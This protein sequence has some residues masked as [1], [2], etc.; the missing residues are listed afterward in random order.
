MGA[1]RGADAVELK[2]LVL[3]DRYRIYQ[4]DGAAGMATVC[5]ARDVTTSAVVTVLVLEPPVTRDAG[6]VRRF[7]R[8]AEMAARRT[9]PYVAPIEDYGQEQG[10]C[11]MVTRY[12]Q[13]ATLRDVEQQ[14][15]ALPMVQCAWIT[16]CIASALEGALSSG[17]TFHGALRPENV[18]MTAS[19]D[20]Q[21]AGFGIAAASGAPDEILGRS[22]TRYAAPEQVEGR[23]IDIR[24]DLYA[25]GVM[26]YE[27]LTGHIPAASEAHAFLGAEDVA[28]T[29]DRMD[30]FLKDVPDQLRP[31]LSG[32]LAWD[33]DARFASPGDLIAMLVLAGFPAPQ[34][35]SLEPE[36]PAI[37][38]GPVF[39]M[40]AVPDVRAGPVSIVGMSE[41]YGQERTGKQAH[42]EEAASVAGSA[43]RAEVPRPEEGTAWETGAA[44]QVATHQPTPTAAAPGT[45][46]TRRRRSV[47]P[48]VLLVVVIGVVAYAAA[49]GWLSGRKPA[50]EGTTTPP[51]NQTVTTG[52]LEITSTPSGASITIDDK[53]IGATTPTTVSGLAPGSHTILLHLS[54]YVDSRKTVAVT[55]GRTAS[56]QVSL[57]KKADTT[58]PGT[59]PSTPV[60]P[61]QVQT[62]IR[63]TSTPAGAAITLDGKA[64]GSRTP[65]TLDVAPGGHLV[66]LSL[67]GYTTLTRSVDVT[68]GRHAS[69][70]V[71]LAKAPPVVSGL[72]RVTSKPAGAKVKVDGKVVAGTTPLTVSVAV[73]SH[74]LQVSLQGYET[75]T[76]TRVDVVKGIETVVVAQLVPVPADKD[77]VNKVSGFGFRY[78]GTWQIVQSQGSTEPPA[79][80]EVRSP[81]GASVRVTVTDAGG[82]T[83]EAYTAALKVELEKAGGVV[84]AVGPRTV[85]GIVYEHLVCTQGSVRTE[86]CML[87]SAGSMYRLACS[88]P[89]DGIVAATPGFLVILG[90]FYA[91][92]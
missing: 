79:W 86:Y 19:G 74:A 82:A 37:Q 85:K 67:S 7:L 20:A 42:P 89:V 92:P 9:Q 49:S 46:K 24:T 64:T 32:L 62:T 21:V 34:R 5:L 6:S 8:S 44:P 26:V 3:H 80:A 45:V 40:P 68:K 87:L 27:M 63:I 55:S 31:M 61:A 69:L 22:A 1:D 4:Q 53:T 54:G 84:S 36:A 47:L 77:Y 51:A 72:L 59:E 15:G 29:A 73:G 83:V 70:A 66:A 23:A 14:A 16:A 65:A 88:A 91:A 60:T 10:V 58:K 12:D 13:Q 30:D 52:K 38:D 57:A 78:P 41:F 17:I 81:Q 71:T 76:R 18:V 11:Y 90:S 56:A 35:P 33:P 48:L 39:D 25:L 50:P 43:T 75:Y 2:G 28:G